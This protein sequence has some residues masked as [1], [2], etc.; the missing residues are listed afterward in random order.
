MLKV[1]ALFVLVFVAGCREADKGRATELHA[2]DLPQPSAEALSQRYF[3]RLLIV[4]GDDLH[5]AFGRDLSGLG[6]EGQQLQRLPIVDAYNA[7][8]AAALRLEDVR[9]RRRFMLELFDETEP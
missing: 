2:R 4:D 1:F 3:Q 9:T 8:H 6:L 5:S 7:A